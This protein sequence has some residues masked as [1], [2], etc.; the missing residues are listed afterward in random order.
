MWE[1]NTCH[2]LVKRPEILLNSALQLGLRMCN[3]LHVKLAIGWKIDNCNCLVEGCEK[4]LYE[5][6]MIH[7]A[8]VA[9]PR[10]AI[11]KGKSFPRNGQSQNENIRPNRQMPLAGIQSAPLQKKFPPRCRDRDSNKIFWCRL[12]GTGNRNFILL[13][14]DRNT[15]VR[16][17]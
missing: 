14:L 3:L 6:L 8:K 13:P 16:R 2:I 1:R 10:S 11:A 17:S 15:M 12:P 5:I 4:W 7:V 9:S